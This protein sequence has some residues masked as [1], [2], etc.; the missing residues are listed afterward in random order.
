V[1]VRRNFFV[2]LPQARKKLLVRTPD[3]L[4]EEVLHK[5]Y[6]TDN[7]DWFVFNKRHSSRTR[8]WRTHQ[9]CS[10]LVLILLAS[11]AVLIKVLI[12]ITLIQAA[13]AANVTSKSRNKGQ[14]GERKGRGHILLYSRQICNASNIYFLFGNQEAFLLPASY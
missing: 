11:T 3:D 10:V 12:I 6:Y 7:S 9:Q 13:E 14:Q 5:K 2:N 8:T 4:E 1:F